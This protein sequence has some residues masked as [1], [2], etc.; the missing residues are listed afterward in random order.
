MEQT[1]QTGQTKVNQLVW[2][3]CFKFGMDKLGLGMQE[4]AGVFS[5]S[6]VCTEFAP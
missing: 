4:F 1:G 3:G 5:L 2:L 6:P